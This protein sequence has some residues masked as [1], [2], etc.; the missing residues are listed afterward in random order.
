MNKKILYIALFFAASLLSSCSENVE[1]WNPE[2]SEYT[3][4]FVFKV[5]NEDMTVVTHDYDG[6]ELSIFNTA[7]NL[8]NEIWVE[9][10][11]HVENLKSKFFLTGTPSNFSSNSNN[12]DDLTNNIL[13]T[14]V[15]SSSPTAAD[16]TVSVNRNDVRASLIEGK[17]LKNAAKSIGNNTVDSIYMKVQFHAGILNFKSFEVPVDQRADPDVEEFEWKYDSATE[18][19]ADNRVIVIAGYRYTGLP[20]DNF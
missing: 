1:N 5:L 6:A 4:R 3:G 2:T 19:T 9:D 20:E 8:E 12:F 16:Q 11:D 7:A 17:I 14:G 18:N 10:D 15:P 13:N